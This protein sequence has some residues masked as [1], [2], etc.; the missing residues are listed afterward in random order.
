LLRQ[1][2]A[3][4]VLS[5]ALTA[6]AFAQDMGGLRVRITDAPGNPLAVATVRVQTSESL[7]TKSG[8]T[9]TN[10]EVNLMGLDPSSDYEVSVNGA[11]Y[12]SV[13]SEDVQVV[14]GRSFTLEYALKPAGTQIQEI[15][16]QVVP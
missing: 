14:S 12:Q 5:A 10:G 11:G 1:S 6:T 3:T 7:T 15:V 13:R 2:I 9:G 4:A 8:T 16:V